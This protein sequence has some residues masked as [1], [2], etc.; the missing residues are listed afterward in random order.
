MV[1]LSAIVWFAMD[2]LILNEEGYMKINPKDM[3][4][5]LLAGGT[6]GEREI[7]LASG[8]GAGDALREAGFEVT[9]LGE[10]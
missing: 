3:H 7:S 1:G 4:V 10:D 6:S 2:K 5:V 8:K 9:H